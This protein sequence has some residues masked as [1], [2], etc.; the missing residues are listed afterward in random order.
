MSIFIIELPTFDL[1]SITFT[2][3]NQYLVIIEIL[4]RSRN[5]FLNHKGDYQLG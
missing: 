1:S 2:H 5:T 4:F 3:L